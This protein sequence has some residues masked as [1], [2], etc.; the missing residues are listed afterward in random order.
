MSGRPLGVWCMG[1]Q[2]QWSYPSLPPAPRPPLSHQ[3]SL[4]DGDRSANLVS[5][6]QPLGVNI[7]NRCPPKQEMCPC[8]AAT[9][10]PGAVPGRGVGDDTQPWQP[11][12]LPGELLKITTQDPSP[13]QSTLGHTQMLTDV[14]KAPP[15]DCV[16]RPGLRA[17]SRLGVQPLDHP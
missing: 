17:R 7:A 3:R 6:P 11:I 12:R 10:C 14:L 5:P 8:L 1:L 13:G 4:P 9:L 2:A 16:I 15:G